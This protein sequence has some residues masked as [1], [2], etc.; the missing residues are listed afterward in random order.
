MGPRVS[1]ALGLI[2]LLALLSARVAPVGASSTITSTGNVADGDT[3]NSASSA[4]PCQS[5]VAQT[6]SSM[7]KSTAVENALGSSYYAE[8]IASYFSPTYNSIFQIDKATAPYPICT[9]KVLSFNVVFTLKNSAGA[10]AGNL[11][12]T[13]SQNLTVI[14]SSLQRQPISANSH[15][16]GWAGYQVTA[17]SGGTKLINESFDEY[18]QPTP[19]Y[20]S[21]GCGT[22]NECNVIVWVGMTDASL[23]SDGALVQAGTWA[24]CAYSSGSC[25][26]SY[27]AFY[28]VCSYGC[29]PPYGVQCT[30]SN[31]GNVV[32]GGGDSIYPDVQDEAASGGDPHYYDFYTVDT[33]SNTSCYISGDKDPQLYQPSYGQFMAEN[34]ITSNSQPLAD[35]G[36]FS[37]VDAGIEVDSGH[38]GNINSYYPTAYDMENQAGSGG[39]CSGSL[40]TNIQEGT[41]GSGGDFTSTWKSSQYTP[42]NGC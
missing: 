5:A 17:N 31:G 29:G 28:E 35:F 40:V 19:G 16:I 36:S 24:T 11:V 21:T 30:T 6:Y 42:P 37:T 15:D 4:A 12:I 26:N 33:T 22:S 41:L 1:S 9:E 10:W 23:G 20:P 34:G 7:D 8:G 3:S 13:E 2:F 32:I 27:F 39:S 14:G 25:T 38:T 18:Y